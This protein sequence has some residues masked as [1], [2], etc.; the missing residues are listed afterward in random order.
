M[1]LSLCV[2]Q[3]SIPKPVK[4]ATIAL[5]QAD[6]IAEALETEEINRASL[7][8]F[9]A[10]EEDRRAA[11]RI[12]GMRYEIYGPKVTF[13]SRLEGVPRKDKGKEVA[14]EEEQARSQADRLDSGRRRLIEVVGEYGKQGWKPPIVAVEDATIGAAA[15][16]ETAPTSSQFLPVGAPSTPLASLPP[17]AS[18]TDIFD[19]FEQTG[20]S[21][22]QAVAEFLLPPP[23][24]PDLPAPSSPFS[25]P[26]RPSTSNI[27]LPAEL[28]VSLPSPSTSTLLPPLSSVPLK[29]PEPIPIE[30]T[31]P[32]SPPAEP[33]SR[34]YL[35]LSEVEETA[36]EEMSALFGDHHEWG[37]VKVVPSR[38][39][40]LSAF[41]FYP[42]MISASGLTFEPYFSARKVP[43]CVITGL[44]ALYRDPRTLAPYASVAAYQTLTRVIKQAYVWNDTLGAFTGTSGV[45]LQKEIERATGTSPTKVNGTG[46]SKGKARASS[47]TDLSNPYAQPYAARIPRKERATEADLINPST[48]QLPP[49]VPSSDPALPTV[50]SPTLV[51]GNGHANGTVAPPLPPPPPP[52]PPSQ[53]MGRSISS[54]FSPSFSVTITA[55]P[56]PKPKSAVMVK[57]KLSAQTTTTDAAVVVP[58]QNGEEVKLVEATSNGGPTGS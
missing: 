4:K 8:A 26:L 39:R 57:S 25:S 15:R 13:L 18:N 1:N 11:D 42:S 44:P 30:N 2:T 56:K 52:P 58:V 32:K 55:K 3:A 34:N 50:S 33:H 7:L 24:S 47:T 27:A 48:P 43:S 45:G 6:L 49:P 51:N 10:A 31:A 53:P 22:S 41:P 17:K 12:A 54:S 46:A 35:I 9:Y 23:T 14:T 38:S 21:S 20:P 40:V 16:G 37:S 28:P 19:N 5:T 36:A 29:L